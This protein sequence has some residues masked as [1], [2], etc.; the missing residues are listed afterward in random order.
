[1]EIKEITG[2]YIT[3]VYYKIK[4]PAGLDIYIYPKENSSSTYAIFGTKYGSID[5][6]FQRSDEAKPETVPEGIAHYLEHKLFESE[7]GDAFSRYAETGASANAFTSFDTTCYL[8]SATD[9]VYD[10]LEI[11]LDFVQSPYFTEETVAKEQGII[12]Q[13]IRMYDDDPQWKLFFNHL[14]ALY[15]NHPIKKDIAGTV[16]SIAKITPELLYR[17]YDTFY[18]LNNMAL[19]IAGNVDIDKV[20]EVCDKML[21]PSKPVSVDR[22]FDE[23]PDE[24]V[25]AYV[26]EKMAVASPLF[27]FGYKETVRSENRTERDV[28]AVEVLLEILASDASPLFRSMLDEGL[29]NESS[30]SYD[31]FE[32]SGYAS[33][34]FSGESKDPKLV[35]ERIKNEIIRLKADGIPYDAFERSKRAVYGENIRAMNRV[36]NIANGIINRVFKD[37][38]LFSYIDVFPALTISDVEEKLKNIFEE[39]KSALSVI[40]PL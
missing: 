11:L 4:H 23:E 21:K 32:G 10:S 16:E 3:D 37:R 13:E 30:F 34:N 25:T 38:E 26:E 22:V 27:Q 6:C 17:C 28:A 39:G 12:G 31:Y 24:I 1:M 2:K 36:S 19:C 18:N 20:L 15:Y 5:S 8:F 9:R 40:L 14:A 33:I 7:D 35:S 29:I